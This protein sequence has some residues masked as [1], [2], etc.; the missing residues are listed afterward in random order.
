[1]PPPLPR[2]LDSPGRRRFLA[3]LGGL[4]LV[5]GLGLRPSSGEANLSPERLRRSMQS[6][7]GAQG[8][9][10]LE[11]WFAL[12]ER[13]RPAD[14][15]TRLREVNAFFNRRVRWL[16][17]IDIWGQE[18]YWATPLETLGRG[19][20]DCEDFSIAKYITLKE[21]GV[22]GDE[23]RM[24]YVR[25]RI[26]RSGITQAHMVLGYYETPAADPLVLDNLMPSI[27][28]G[29]QRNDLDPLFSFNSSGLWAG[30][31]T[32]SRAD[33]LARLSRWRRAV[34]RMQEQGFIQGG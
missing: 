20:G 24:I 4:S 11:A 8:L 10:N 27:T 22:P 9:E 1:M 12:L 30:S 6:N 33:P 18:D 14:L 34:G 26:G 13:L 21:L 19:Q 2:T 15:Q 17:D 3:G 5:I 25:A 32:R 23:L 16:D 29:S 31:S 7:H 28:R